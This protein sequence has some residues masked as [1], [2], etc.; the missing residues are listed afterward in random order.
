MGLQMQAGVALAIL[1]YIAARA[2]SGPVSTR[3]TALFFGSYFFSLSFSRPRLV[4]GL[5][6]LLLEMRS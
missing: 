5:D 4:T 3:L 1:S 2:L 6:E